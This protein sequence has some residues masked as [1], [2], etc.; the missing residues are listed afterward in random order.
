MLETYFENILILVVAGSVYLLELLG[1]LTTSLVTFIFGTSD[2][3]LA[4]AH[5]API[6]V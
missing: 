5:A 1:T 3:N 6:L 4:F 2:A